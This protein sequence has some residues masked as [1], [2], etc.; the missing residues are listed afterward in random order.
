MVM[1]KGMY[2]KGEEYKKLTQAQ[3]DKLKELRDVPN[4]PREVNET[5]TD[6]PKLPTIVEE[7]KP[8]EQVPKHN[9]MDV[10]SRK[11]NFA[12]KGP[13]SIEFKGRIY[14]VQN[15]NIAY[16]VANYDVVKRSGALVDGGANGGLGG[17]D[18]RVIESTLLKADVSG[19][20]NQQITNIPIVS[21]AAKIMTTSGPIIGIFHQYAH[22]G[23]GGTIHSC[24]QLRA[25]GIEVDDIP[26]KLSGK[27]RIRHPDGFI[28]PLHVR[29]GLA[30]MD[31]EYPTDEDLLTLEVAIFTNDEPWDPR[32][33]D[34]EHS[35]H[36]VQYTE[37][38]LTPDW[39][40]MEEIIPDEMELSEEEIAIENNVLKF[41]YQEEF[42]VFVEKCLREVHFK[43]VDPAKQQLEDLAPNLGFIPLN[44]IEK[45]IENTTQ[46]GKLDTRFPM[47]HHYKLRNPAHNVKRAN[48]D[49]A[50]DAIIS[51][52]PAVYDG[53]SGH[54]GCTVLQ[55]FHGWRTKY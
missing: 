42:D 45:T 21:G 24:A 2:F 50:S 19:I 17:K 11:V 40:E 37:E 32:K 8:V 22:H 3:K 7:E 46:W 34:G 20:A 49:F 15:H 6:I 5:I 33:L 28:I 30:Y 31:M 27:Q 44:R 53:I 54:A 4:T 14:K 43:K 36:K 41:A 29:N 23:K 9:I 48:D 12:E 26:I 51:A 18:L 16:N 52:V 47:R 39:S 10:L 25:Y 1:T 35:V 13:D 55:F 38:E